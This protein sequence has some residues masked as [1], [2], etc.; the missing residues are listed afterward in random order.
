MELGDWNWYLPRWLDRLPTLS[1]TCIGD[2]RAANRAE[3]RSGLA[4]AGTALRPFRK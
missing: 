3:T 2:R 1:R 4:R